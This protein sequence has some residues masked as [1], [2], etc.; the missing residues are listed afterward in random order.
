M[1]EQLATWETYSYMSEILLE[2]L[3]LPASNFYMSYSIIMDSSMVIANYI[4]DQA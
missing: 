4:F 1:I 3:S 2:N